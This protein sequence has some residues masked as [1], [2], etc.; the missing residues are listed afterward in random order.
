[1]VAMSGGVD[2]AV[3]AYLL[4]EEGYEIVGVTMR[5]MPEDMAETETGCFGLSAAAS[6]IAS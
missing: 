6:V 4:K 5:F 2:S 1:M 3:T